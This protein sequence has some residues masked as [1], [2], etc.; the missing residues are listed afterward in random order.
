[1]RFAPVGASSSEGEKLIA[2][3]VDL[4]DQDAAVARLAACRHCGERRVAEGRE[5]AS[6]ISLIDRADDLGCRLRHAGRDSCSAPACRLPAGRA[7]SP[8]ATEISEY[9]ETRERRRQGRPFERRS[10]APSPRPRSWAMRRAAVQLV[11]DAPDG[12]LA[13]FL[14]SG[15]DARFH[16]QLAQPVITSRRDSDGHLEV[17]GPVVLR[18]AT[19]AGP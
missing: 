6:Q 14:A 17:G 7:H 18:G 11:G 3:P 9:G 8:A 12:L 1:M 19:R 5:H 10:T 2:L 13:R 15:A 4:A 16:Q